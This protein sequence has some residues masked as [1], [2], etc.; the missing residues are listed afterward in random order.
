MKDIRKT[1]PRKIT[2]IKVDWTRSRTN[3]DA[4]ELVLDFLNEL[5]SLDVKEVLGSDLEYGYSE[6]YKEIPKIDPY[7]GPHR[8]TTIHIRG[9]RRSKGRRPPFWCPGNN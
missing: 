9:Q 4:K 5:D 3:K 7:V 6:A 1:D 2:I 8:T